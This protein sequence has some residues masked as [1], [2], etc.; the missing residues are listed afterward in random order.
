MRTIYGHEIEVISWLGPA[1]EESK[2]A[3]RLMKIIQ[4]HRD[5]K[6]WIY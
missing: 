6:D 3:F 1:Y 5:S 2:L 4:E